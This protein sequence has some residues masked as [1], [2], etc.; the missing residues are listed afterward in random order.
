LAIL[1]LTNTVTKQ[2]TPFQASIQILTA[3]K[4]TSSSQDSSAW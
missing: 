1:E 2:L 3:Q 4:K